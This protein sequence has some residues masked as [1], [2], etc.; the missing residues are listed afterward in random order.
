MREKETCKLCREL[1]EF[2]T[3][4]QLTPFH[5]SGLLD[6]SSVFL[7]PSSS[8][9]CMLP[10]GCLLS[11]RGMKAVASMVLDRGG[12]TGLAPEIKLA[13]LANGIISGHTEHRFASDSFAI[14]ALVRKIIF[15]HPAEPMME[16]ISEV[17]ND[18]MIKASYVHPKWRLCGHSA[19]KH[20]WLSQL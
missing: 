11:M 14:A 1:V 18:W 7:T 20:P 13:V 16:Q 19:L 3:G 2:L 10:L 5:L 6:E 17:G 9:S 8:L 12:C 15:W 4:L